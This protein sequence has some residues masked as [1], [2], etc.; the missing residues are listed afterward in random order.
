MTAKS[1]LF[2]RRHVVAMLPAALAGSALAARR[3]PIVLR[4][5]HFLGPD[6]FF[7]KELIEP[8]ARQLEAR[9]HGLVSVIVLS[10]ADRTGE[11]TQQAAN[12]ESGIVDIA[13][14]LRGGE[15]QRFPGSSL[16]E[17]PL[18]V[19]DAL[20]G[21]RV[22]W[23]LHQEGVLASEYAKFKL[24]ALFVHNPG[25]VH[26]VSKRVE[27]P[28]DMKG[29]RLRVPGRPA[30]IALSR[31]G[32][33]PRVLQVNDVMPAVRS[34][35]IDGVVTNWGTPLPGFYQ[36]LHHHTA[37][38]FYSAAFFIVMNKARFAALPASVRKA[39]EALSGPQFVDSI[40]RSWNRWDGTG[41]AQASAAGQEI[42]R[43][44]STDMD[45][46]R[47][48]LLPA[49]DQY[50]D[51]LSASYPAARAVHQRIMALTAEPRSGSSR[52]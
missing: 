5:S 40:A 41:M 9:C 35:A 25:I 36:T 24:L 3:K 30:E 1:N 16:I 26:T 48:A 19:K 28:E 29:L 49:V 6:S 47:S 44:S 42:I 37:V 13:L 32:A 15:P 33:V 21:S 34:G 11:V 17:V 38:P 51:E 27:R 23:Q 50:V 22:L 43:P 20:Q 31:L 46:W 45:R 14:G 39:I 18:A 10:G 4:F 2:S 8:W 12:V 7:Q 52:G